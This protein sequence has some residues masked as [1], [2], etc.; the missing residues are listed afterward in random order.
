MRPDRDRLEAIQA[1]VREQRRATLRS[2]TISVTLVSALEDYA[3]QVT[4]GPTG[5]AERVRLRRLWCERALQMLQ[6]VR[7]STM[8]A[9]E[10]A[11]KMSAL[12]EAEGGDVDLSELEVS[13]R[14]ADA[15]VERAE[16]TARRWMELAV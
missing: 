8:R 6:D 9:R 15:A 16:E 4:Q 11:R 13:S 5:D 1:L 12:V 10:V 14:E 2:R 3:R 7:A